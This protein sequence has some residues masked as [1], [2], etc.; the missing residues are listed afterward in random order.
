MKSQVDNWSVDYEWKT[1]VVLALGFG[2]VGLDR[3][4][5]APLFPFIM[6]DLGINFSQLGAIVGILGIGWGVSAIFFGNLSDVLGRRSVLIPALLLFSLLAGFT[7]LAGSFMMLM[8]LRLIM[9]VSEGAF[10]PASSAATSEASNPKRRGFNQG[11]QLSLFAFLGLGLGPIIATQLLQ[12]VP[13]WRYV[14]MLVSI[15]GFLLAIF[16][17]FIIREPG[18]EKG[19]D[20]PV[21]HSRWG[22]VFGSRNVILAVLG[23]LSSMCCIFVIGAMIPSYLMD[24]LKLSPQTMGFVTSAVGFGGFFG[25][26]GVPGLSDLLGRRNAAI[27]SFL[28]AIPLLYAFM[29]TGPNPT[30]LFVL[31]F[32]IGMFTLGLLGLFTG[33]I[34]TEGVSPKAKATAIGLVSGSG[35]IFGGG[36]AP[37]LGGYIAQHYGLPHVLDLAMAGLVLGLVVVLFLRETAPRFAKA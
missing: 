36:I 31:L 8:T 35:E 19:E 32:F 22:E 21:H 5:I 37:A 20:H 29:H 25:E 7:G 1:V 33:P 28:A 16:V 17:Y 11:F 18:R 4:I 24:V 6:K 26:F 27:I 23:I 15:P 30:L 9:G 34:A 13:S 12:I 3:W 2:L 10:L 14:F